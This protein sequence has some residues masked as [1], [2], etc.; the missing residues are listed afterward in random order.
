MKTRISLVILASLTFALVGCSRHS[1]ATKANQNTWDLGVVEVSEGVQIQRDLGGGRVCTILPAIQKDGSVL[2][3]LKL[4]QNGKLLTAARI[5]TGSDREAVMRTGDISIDVT[6]HIRPSADEKETV[7]PGRHM[8][9]SQIAEIAGRELPGIQNFSCQF[10]N[11][12]WEIMDVQTGT[13]VSSTTT[14][15]D[16]HIFVRSTH[17]MQLVLRVSDA[18]GK[19]EQVKTP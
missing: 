8:S 13:W 2:M 10:T 12:V 4:T 9:E 1:A 19:I 16:G 5:Q 15:A 3:N 11:G 7:L 14:N 18:D 17:P 6:P